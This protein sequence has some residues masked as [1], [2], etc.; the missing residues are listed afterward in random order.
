MNYDTAP[1]EQ[2]RSE[3]KS[4]WSFLHLVSALIPNLFSNLQV[5][6]FY[7]ETG[8]WIDQA[9]ESEIRAK[10]QAA[11]KKIDELILLTNEKLPPKRE[12]REIAAEHWERCG[13]GEFSFKNGVLCGW[14]L[15]RFECSFLHISDDMPYHA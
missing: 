11:I 6:S 4:R 10:A 3:L 9:V 8:E 2:I 7:R 1:I 12:W 15:E 14:L 13:T 5:S